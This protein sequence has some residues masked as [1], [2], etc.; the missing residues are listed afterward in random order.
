MPQTGLRTSSEPAT[1]LPESLTG[2]ALWMSH[3][4]TWLASPSA[5]SLLESESGRLHF[6]KLVGEMIGEFGPAA[7]HASLSP[8]QA[9]ALGLMT[10]GICGPHGTT[11]LS[12]AALQ[13]SLESKLQARMP[14]S[15]GI[16]FK[17][18]WK[19]RT[20]PQGRRICALRA[21]VP[22]TSDSDCGGWGTPTKDEAGGTAEQFLARKAA[23]SGAC[24]VSLTALNLQAQLASWPTAAA[25]DWKDGHEQNVPTNALLGRVAWLAS[26]KSPTACSPNS[27]RGNG[28]DPEK[29]IAGGHQVNLQDQVRLAGWPTTTTTTEATTHC[30]GPGKTI[31]LKTYGAARLADWNDTWPVGT[32][33]NLEGLSLVSGPTPSG[34]P[35]ATASGGQLNPAHSRWLMGLPPEWDDCAPTATRSSRRSRPSGSAS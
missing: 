31:Q 17:L 16:L 23:L 34:S 13:S 19:Q 18:T 14:L 12:S 26:W 9:K 28:Q 20:T 35:A 22:R 32:K 24:G 5:I 29:R 15:G 10:S 30:Y 27:L 7:V 2:A 3:P 6:A 25:R 21:S 11:S 8:Q 33:A 4:R 1:L